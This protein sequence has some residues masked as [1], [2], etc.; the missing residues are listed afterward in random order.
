MK[1]FL[2]SV[3]ICVAILLA[4]VQTTHAVISETADLMI[5]A[6]SGI[7]Q[8]DDEKLVQEI[9][10]NLDSA[11]KEN[12]RAYVEKTRP[13]INKETKFFNDTLTPALAFLSKIPVVGDMAMSAVFSGYIYSYESDLRDDADSNVLKKFAELREHNIDAG[14]AMFEVGFDMMFA[15]GDKN[16]V[17][18]VDTALLFTKGAQQLNR[19]K[20]SK[21]AIQVV[22]K[23]AGI[24]IYNEDI[25][26]ICIRTSSGAINEPVVQTESKPAVQ[27]NPA[28]K[29]VAPPPAKTAT[30]AT[31]IGGVSLGV[32][33][34]YVNSKFGN[35]SKKDV[36][37]TGFARLSYGDALAVDYDNNAASCIISYAPNQSTAKG[38]HVGSSIKDFIAAYGD[39]YSIYRANGLEMYEYFSNVEGRDVITR[40]AVKENSDKV[41][42]ISIR[43]AD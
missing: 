7:M 1:K 5:E 36:A 26:D 27:S 38:I 17:S 34:D 30:S 6:A 18:T 37:P 16:Q 23:A 35:P 3:M 14:K 19:Y 10:Q 41:Y 25:G 31:S 15:S 20:S 33:I 42:Y 9:L 40:F 8:N 12:L 28:P 29:P 13:L 11:E 2:A 21:E 43:Y 39:D 22:L 4:Q 32:S 24:S